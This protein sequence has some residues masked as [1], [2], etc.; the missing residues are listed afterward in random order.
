MHVRID[1]AASARRMGAFGRC[2]SSSSATPPPPPRCGSGRPRIGRLG[3]PCSAG[4]PA[5]VCRPLPVLHSAVAG[6]ERG[7]A[8]CRRCSP[9]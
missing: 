5:Y 9:T 1:A 8:S 7:A 6:S 2:Q 4:L 3:P